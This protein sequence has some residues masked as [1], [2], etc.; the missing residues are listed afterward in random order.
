ME[1]GNSSSSKL[2]QS[3]GDIISSD[4]GDRGEQG[5]KTVPCMPSSRSERG[6][7]RLLYAQTASLTLLLLSLPGPLWSLRPPPWPWPEGGSRW[8]AAA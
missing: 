6:V 8:R 3:L 5:D 7:V 1:G 2:D 4:K